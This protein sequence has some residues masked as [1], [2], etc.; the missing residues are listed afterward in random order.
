MSSSGE[1][2]LDQQKHPHIKAIG[3]TVQFRKFETGATRDTDSGKFDYEGFICPFV[4][5][6]FGEYMHR[7]RIQSDGTLRDSCNWQRGIPIA[8][9]VKSLIRH[10]MEAWRVHRGGK[11]SPKTERDPQS[12]EDDLCAIIF[13]AQ[14]WLHEILKEKRANAN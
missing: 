14:G 12:I 9:Y 2:L 13:N 1:Y 10:V 4:L 7:H 6:R 8:Q 5:E 3:E 11:V